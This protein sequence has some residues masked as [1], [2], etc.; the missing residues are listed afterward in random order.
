MGGRRWSFA[1]HARSVACWWCFTASNV[2]ITFS[3]SQLGMYATVAGANDR[4]KL[5]PRLAINA[6]GWR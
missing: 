4:A 5:A 1:L 2:F 6:V 3:L